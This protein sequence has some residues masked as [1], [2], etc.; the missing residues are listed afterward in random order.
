MARWQ[1]KNLY[2]PATPVVSV[3]TTG[4]G[5]AFVAGLLAALAAEGMN[6]RVVSMPCTDLLKSSQP[7]IKSL[8]FLKQ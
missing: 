1:G 7:S 2:F 8:S 6:V 4:A 3:D 5:D